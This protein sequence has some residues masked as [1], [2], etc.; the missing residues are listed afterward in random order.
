MDDFADRDFQSLTF[1]LT[2]RSN[3]KKQS[4]GNDTGKEP[5]K[6]LYRGEER[7]N[8][9]IPETGCNSSESH[10]KFLNFLCIQI[11]TASDASN[12]KP[13]YLRA[14]KSFIGRKYKRI[15]FKHW[16]LKPTSR[17]FVFPRENRSCFRSARQQST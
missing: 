6:I 14:V 16:F 2:E 10:T 9:S 17:S 15:A 12:S 7:P 4:N 13:Q 5:F 11:I 3:F 8:H 1:G